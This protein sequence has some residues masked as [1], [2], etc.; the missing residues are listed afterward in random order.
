MLRK[1]H[2]CF[3]NFRFQ[4]KIALISILSSIVPLIVLT[5]V[6]VSIIRAF[7]QQQEKSAYSDN[8]K[9]ISYQLESKIHTYRDSLLFL[10]NNTALTQEL[11]SQR[12]SNFDQYNLFQN[13]IV[14]L[15]HSVRFP[16][17]D[18]KGITLYTTIDLYDHGQ[19]VKK[20]TADTALP[21]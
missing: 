9:S 3:K 12:F 15:F 4:K 6:G 17:A 19:Y 11:S 1:V 7:I 8:L 18:I 5:N 2:D 10:A 21:F 16:Q 14:P 20:I 13:T